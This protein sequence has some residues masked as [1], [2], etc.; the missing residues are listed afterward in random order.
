M[1]QSTTTP[2]TASHIIYR[3]KSASPLK[4]LRNSPYKFPK[5]SSSLSQVLGHP[6]AHPSPPP[7]LYRLPVISGELESPQGAEFFST[8]HVQ[9]DFDLLKD[10]EPRIP[11][12]AQYDEIFKLFPTAYK[13]SF[14]PPFLV[15]VCKTLPS[16]PW[17]VTVASMPLFLTDK[18]NVEPM[19]IGLYTHGPKV[20]IKSAIRRWQTPNLAAFKEVFQV[21]DQFSKDFRRVQWT[22]ATFVAIASREP[23][24]D[25]RKRLPCMINSMLI[26]Y[27]FDESPLMETAVR[28]IVP[29]GQVFDDSQ[30]D[31]LRPGIMIVSATGSTQE[32]LTTSGVCLQ[33]PSSSKKY[34]TVASH[35]FPGSVGDIVIHPNRNG[36]CIADVSKVFGET[37]IAL[38]ELRSQSNVAY[39]RT[40]FSTP[41][42]TVR[43]F[44]NLLSLHEM[45]VHDLVYMDTAVNGR[46]EGSLVKV[47]VLR[48]PPDDP[49]SKEVEY[50]IGNF[51]YFGNG[52]DILLDGCR[53]APLWNDNHDVIGQ[54]RFVDASPA[55]LCYCPSFSALKDFGY[56]I[57]STT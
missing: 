2:P 31:Q 53:G 18:E 24:A 19:E 50:A 26:G 57:A 45:R 11:S 37:D 34:I 25:W 29:Q 55:A 4:I 20:T 27:V 3:Q 48:L 10:G 9:L 52:M 30:Y 13:L 8:R 32:L 22:G 28:K 42:A 38:A 16:K 54:F 56:T 7:P 47:E 12:K 23:F 36:L 5:K 6:H 49:T 41:E 1:L 43:P 46:C 17:P 51:V 14:A 33:S 15:I 40:T 39:S 21:L 44:G 35:G